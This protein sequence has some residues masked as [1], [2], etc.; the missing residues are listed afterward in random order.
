GS[1]RR[2]IRAAGDGVFADNDDRAIA[3]GDAAL[4]IGAAINRVGDR[5]GA[6][7]LLGQAGD[8]VNRARTSKGVVLG[9]IANGDGGRLDGDVDID[10]VGSAGVVEQGVVSR[11]EH[12]GINNEGKPIGGDIHI[13]GRRAS[14][15]RTGPNERLGPVGQ[16]KNDSQPYCV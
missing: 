1:T 11:V 9:I 3:H 5:K 8:A 4:E 15:V 13:P 14:G 10:V 6:A 7:T 2:N 12:V 16:N